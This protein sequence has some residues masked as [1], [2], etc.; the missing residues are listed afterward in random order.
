LL[1]WRSRFEAGQGVSHLFEN[2]LSGDVL[3]AN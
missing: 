2:V 1:M 3:S